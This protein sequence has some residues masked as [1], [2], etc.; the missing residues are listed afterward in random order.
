MMRDREIKKLLKEAYVLPETEKEKLFIRKYEKRFLQL[1]GIIKIELQ[2]MGVKSI[3]AGIILTVLLLTAAK[4]EDTELVWI[5]TSFIPMCALVPMALISRSER[6]GMSE[7]EAAS[8]FSLRFIRIVRM[9]VL[10]LFSTALLLAVGVI[11]RVTS[12]A[13]VT[14]QMIFVV[15]PY[16]ISTY[17]AM[18]VTRKWHGKENIFGI[19]VACAFSGLLPFVMRTARLSGQLTG[20]L[21]FPVIVLLLGAIV[22]ECMLYVKESEDLSWNLC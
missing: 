22:R 13:T 20:G 18:L 19:L 2:Y 12:I 10:G 17:G 4:T 7:M 15:F 5:F 16:L 1:S 21:F 8:R 9:F 6:C 3:L 11:L 14:E